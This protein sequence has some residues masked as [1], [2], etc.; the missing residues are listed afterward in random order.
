MIDSRLKSGELNAKAVHERQGASPDR[1][2]KV[3]RNIGNNIAA[4]I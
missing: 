1:R 4:A 3:A 2:G